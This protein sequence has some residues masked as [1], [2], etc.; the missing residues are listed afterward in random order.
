ML[1]TEPDSCWTRYVTTLT[2]A[3]IA[4]RGSFSSHRRHCFTD[5]QR[6]SG[7]KSRR[8]SVKGRVTAMGLDMSASAQ[9]ATTA[10]YHEAPRPPGPRTVGAQRHQ[11]EER[12]EDVLALGDPG[13]GLHVQR[14]DGEQR[15][16]G[17][18]RAGGAGGPLQQEEEQGRGQRVEDDARR[19]MS[20]GLEPGELAV[21]QVGEPGDRMP[22]QGFGRRECPGHV[23]ARQALGDARVLR[24]VHP[25]VVVHE[26]VAEGGPVESH[27]DQRQR[28]GQHAWTAPKCVEEGSRHGGVDY[29]V[30]GS[31]RNR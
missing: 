19:V 3:A 21:E 16:C 2:A 30:R 10:T 26:P 6:P 7:Q 9:Q 27:R 8:S 25:V 1:T 23:L 4:K 24:H 11:P 17:Q 12:A 29:S 13:H 15:G 14:V 28:Q 5:P 31:A 18:A 20:G 22:V